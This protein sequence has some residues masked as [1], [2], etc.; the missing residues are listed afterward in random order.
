MFLLSSSLPLASSLPCS[1]LGSFFTRASPSLHCL[2]LSPPLHCIHLSSPI[3]SSSSSFSSFLCAF[4]FLSF[5]FSSLSLILSGSLLLAHN[6]GADGPSHPFS[7][8]VFLSLFSFSSFS[9]SS[10]FSSSSSFNVSVYHFRFPPTSSS[11]SS[12]DFVSLSLLLLILHHCRFPL[13]LTS[14]WSRWTCRRCAR[15]C[16]TENIKMERKIS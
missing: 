6:F 2:L 14:F 15:N 12:F 1:T 9:L 5:T 10:S 4:T 13:T 11:F 16:R 7:F 3:C 8:V